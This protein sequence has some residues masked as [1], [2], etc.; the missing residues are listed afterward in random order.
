M[1]PSLLIMAVSELL[2]SLWRT[3]LLYLSRLRHSPSNL[4]V[5]KAFSWNSEISKPKLIF[6]S[7]RPEK[8]H[9]EPKAIHMQHVLIPRPSRTGILWNAAC[10]TE[11][12]TRC[13][14]ALVPCGGVRGDIERRE[15]TCFFSG[16]AGSVAAEMLAC[17]SA[18]VPQFI[19]CFTSL[20]FAH[21]LLSLSLSARLGLSTVNSL[22]L[23]GL[24]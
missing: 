3:S 17:W 20:C 8:A 23:N 24:N 12:H 22:C 2:R 21:F 6:F 19:S 13:P 15:I 9:P 11:I 14:L 18:T 10:V 4:C 7:F 1:A 16:A 5:T